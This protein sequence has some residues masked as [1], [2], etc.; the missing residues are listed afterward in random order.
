MSD[1]P[2]NPLIFDGL[3]R[4]D[5]MTLRDYFAAKALAALITNPNRD[6]ECTMRD[7][8]DEA[9]EL[10]GAMLEARKQ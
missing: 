3:Y 10:A 4:R 1:K 9:Y 6:T 8:A 5:G 2:E 7:L